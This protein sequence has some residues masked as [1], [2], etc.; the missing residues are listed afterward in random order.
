[1]G[2]LCKRPAVATR[3]VTGQAFS[4]DPATQVLTGEHLGSSANISP[5]LG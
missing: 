4:Q 1:M 5:V 3:I 2:L